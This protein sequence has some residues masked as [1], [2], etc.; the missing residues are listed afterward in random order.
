MAVTTAADWMDLIALLFVRN[1]ICP[2]F[3]STW[4]LFQR[5]REV[6][7]KDWWKW[8]RGKC[9]VLSAL[10]GFQASTTPGGSNKSN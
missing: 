6:K 2:T 4:R 8:E 9:P 10:V 5:V 3:M 7:K 1:W